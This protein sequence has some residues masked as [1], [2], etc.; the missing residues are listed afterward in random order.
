M[1]DLKKEVKPFGLSLTESWHSFRLG[2]NYC[3]LIQCE[4]WLNINQSL[5][6]HGIDLPGIDQDSE[7]GNHKIQLQLRYNTF[8]YLFFSSNSDKSPELSDIPLKFIFS[9]H[10]ILADK[11]DSTKFKVILT[12][13]NKDYLVVYY[14]IELYTEPVT[15]FIPAAIIPYETINNKDNHFNLKYSI[16]KLV[17][18]V[19]SYH[20]ARPVIRLRNKRMVLNPPFFIPRHRYPLYIYF[21]AFELMLN[22]EKCTYRL[23][24]AKVKEIF[25]LETFDHN[26]LYRFKKKYFHIYFSPQPLILSPLADFESPC[27]QT[28]DIP[29]EDVGHSDISPHIPSDDPFKDVTPAEGTVFLPTR[30]KLFPGPGESLIS[31]PG[32]GTDREGL[33]G[34]GRFG[35][36]KEASFKTD[37]DVRSRFFDHCDNVMRLF[38]SSAGTHA[39]HFPVISISLPNQPP[40]P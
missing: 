30:P 39:C 6:F 9:S 32:L 15:L 31:Q 3:E 4:D 8:D 11:F 36:N 19:K 28:S 18:G 7:A 21:Y 16:S 40:A 2:D 10:D 17:I 35:V 22:D 24:A 38:Y 33:G 27:L 29:A 13:D 1:S 23:A 26:V 34:L 20:F 14:R 12:I 25:G 37:A 5:W